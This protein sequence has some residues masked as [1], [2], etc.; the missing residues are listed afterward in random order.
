MRLPAVALLALAG[1]ASADPPPEVAALQ[2]RIH[3][4]IEAAEPSVA[5]VLV[6][7]SD[8]YATEFRQGP[9][10]AADGKLGGFNPLPLRLTDARRDMVRR[11]DLARPD[12]VPESYGSGV[13]IDPTG[14]VLTTF[15]V[16][17]GATKVYVRPPGAGRGSYADVVAAD[18][19]A[20]LAV[21]RMLTPPADLKAVP[22]GDGGKVKKGDYV[23]ALANPFAAGFRD[24]SPS[25]SGGIISNLRRQA[26]GDPDETK[27]VK[28]LAQYGMLLQT[29]VRLNAGCSGGALLDLDGRLVGLTTNLAAVAGGETAGGFAVPM[30]AN[31]RTMI[32]VL[33][34]GE[35]IEYG[36]LGVTV[37]PEERSEGGVTIQDVS[38]G[39]P[40]ARAGLL[41]R[42]VVT[43]INGNR[44][45]EQDDL[46]LN[47]SAA[48]AGSEAEIEVLR[49][50]RPLTV[51][52]RLAKANPTEKVIASN[53]PR[54]V[55]GLRVDYA[56]TL[57]IDHQ[58]PE[59]V[60]VR[61][62]ELEPG[63]PA[64]KKLKEWIDRG[65][66]LVVV[67]VDGRP[68]PT[69]ADFY[70]LAGGRPSVTLDVVDVRPGAEGTSQKV[71]L[72]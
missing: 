56:S 2:K 18:A 22:F 27:R 30:D 47:I 54:P 53:R 3:Q 40:A 43:A 13:V 25:A 60:A 15:R 64:E 52:V 39:M 28:P 23:I 42:D 44:V 26:A 8:K 35:E 63:S 11:L 45:R 51:K 32:D 5:C 6:S 24:G 58:P 62:K 65:A 50:R 69:P 20:D 31:T 17:D 19:R 10:A 59:G 41:G 21:L 72:P 61:E 67:A 4:V 55:H 49:N 33:R 70:R 7:R 46:F 29:D 71:T 36:L 37:N 68:V 48:L 38:P 16:I 66:R 34:R 12:T 9:S 57:S 14:L 1:V